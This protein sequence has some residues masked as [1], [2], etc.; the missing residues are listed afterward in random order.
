MTCGIFL[1]QGSNPC[2]LHWRADFPP[3]S[4]PPGKPTIKILNMAFEPMKSGP[5]STPFS[6]ILSCLFFSHLSSSF[7]DPVSIPGASK[8]SLQSFISWC[9]PSVDHSLQLWAPLPPFLA[10]SSSG[11]QP[12]YCFYKEMSPDG[13]LSASPP[14][15]LS[16]LWLVLRSTLY[17][18]YTV[19]ITFII[20]H[21]TCV[22]VCLIGF[23]PNQTESLVTWLYDSLLIHRAW[24][25]VDA[26]YIFIEHS[27]SSYRF[28]LWVQ[29]KAEML[30]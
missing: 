2:L 23:F 26:Q 24:N 1:D 17:F 5:L 22:V 3:L 28:P 8:S 19:F 16:P 13:L 14:T 9:S 29:D 12:A 10:C 18:P 30:K 21:I 27:V 15:S 11:S 4:Q 6:L 20:R 25:I 7:L